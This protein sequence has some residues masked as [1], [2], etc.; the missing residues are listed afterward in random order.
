M[1][2][3][4]TRIGPNDGF[5]TC[6]M[7]M[8]QVI[9]ASNQLKLSSALGIRQRNR[10]DFV[11]KNRTS[12]KYFPRLESRKENEFL[13]RVYSIDR[14]WWLL[15]LSTAAHKNITKTKRPILEEVILAI[16]ERKDDTEIIHSGI[17][18]I[19]ESMGIF[20]LAEHP[21][22]PQSSTQQSSDTSN[23]WD[24]YPSVGTWRVFTNPAPDLEDCRFGGIILESLERIDNTFEAV[25]LRA[26]LWVLSGEPVPCFVN[27]RICKRH[28]QS[29]GNTLFNTDIAW[30]GHSFRV[31]HEDGLIQTVPCPQI[32]L[33]GVSDEVIFEVFGP[34]IREAV[35]ACPIRQSEL[36]NG[37]S[38]TECVSMTFSKDEASIDLSLDLVKGTDIFMKRN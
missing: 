1:T 3:P 24:E 38:R 36:G 9:D 21:G 10:Y 17:R 11:L 26:P 18:R 33:T 16:T 4:G 15:V 6:N 5:E 20:E 27:L 8:K 25:T 31:F 2:D 35:I 14:C 37:I 13:N 7:F 28:V 22:T 19:A 23:P 30:T 34:R 29:L 12:D 32:T